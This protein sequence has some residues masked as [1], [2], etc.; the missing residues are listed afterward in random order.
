MLPP[1][2]ESG[3]GAIAKNGPEFLLRRDIGLALFAGDGDFLVFAG[4]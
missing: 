1:K 3:Q 4:H 2:L